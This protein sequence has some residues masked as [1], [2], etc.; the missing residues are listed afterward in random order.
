MEVN[1]ELIAILEEVKERT[2]QWEMAA[3]KLI[4]LEAK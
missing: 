3:A 2:A 1:R 4:D